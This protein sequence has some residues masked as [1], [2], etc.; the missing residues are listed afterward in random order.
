MWQREYGPDSMAWIG[1]DVACKYGLCGP[2]G[3]DDTPAI[4]AF[5]CRT[6]K[7]ESEIAICSNK[8]LAR[9]EA[10]LAKV[11]FKTLKGLPQDEKDKFRAQQRVWLK[12]RESCKGSDVTSCLLSR[13]DD[14][15]AEI[16]QLKLR[17]ARLP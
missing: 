8:R 2:P 6:A 15:Y 5:D 3:F 14:R 12:Y 11:Y 9:H 13:I 16:L 17:P 7:Q 10:S 1:H 4:P